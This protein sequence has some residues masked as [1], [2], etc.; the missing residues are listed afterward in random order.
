MEDSVSGFKVNVVEVTGAGDA[1]SASMLADLLVFT[2]TEIINLP[3]EKW[4]KILIRAN[5][6]GALACTKQGA[7]PAMPTKVEVSAFLAKNQVAV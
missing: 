1:F 6:A 4:E 5:A 2:N 3:K 7:I